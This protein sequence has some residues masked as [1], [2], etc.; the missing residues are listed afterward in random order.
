MA[1]PPFAGWWLSTR[2]IHPTRE[3]RR[4]HSQV[5]ATVSPM[6]GSTVAVS[7]ELGDHTMRRHSSRTITC[8]QWSLY[9]TTEGQ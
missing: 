3:E 2:L 6:A 8:G 4:L 7:A 5:L 1:G 9:T